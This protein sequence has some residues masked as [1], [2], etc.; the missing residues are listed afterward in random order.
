MFYYS[1]FNCKLISKTFIIDH[2][3]KTFKKLQESDKQARKI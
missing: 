3:D 2:K 1:F